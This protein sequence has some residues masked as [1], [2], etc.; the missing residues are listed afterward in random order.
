MKRLLNLWVEYGLLLLVLVGV[1]LLCAWLGGYEDVLEDVFTIVPQTDDW[2]SRPE[3]LRN[4]RCPFNWWAF[5]MVGVAA[6]ALVT[7][8]VW[9][10]IRRLLNV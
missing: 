10:A 7:P 2:Q 9:R 5:V 6:T 3:K 4:C 1:P 8:F